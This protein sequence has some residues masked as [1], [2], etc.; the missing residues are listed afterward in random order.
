MEQKTSSLCMALY[1]TYDHVKSRT[2]EGANNNTVIEISGVNK[3][4][5]VPVIILQILR[6]LI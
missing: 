6:F 4:I 5:A 1:R 2:G 3:R